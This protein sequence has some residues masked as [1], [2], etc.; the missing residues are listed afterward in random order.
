MVCH[1]FKIV[2]GF[3]FV[4]AVVISLIALFKD[5]SR[6]T[7]S[8]AALVVVENGLDQSRSAVSMGKTNCSARGNVSNFSSMASRITALRPR[9]V[10]Q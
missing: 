7:A 3:Q 6:H 2:D 1:T 4:D 8:A 9:A 5:G 10:N